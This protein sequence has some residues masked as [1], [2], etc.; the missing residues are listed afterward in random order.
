MRLNPRLGECHLEAFRR[1]SRQAGLATAIPWLWYV[2]MRQGR[3]SSRN[4]AWGVEHGARR[5][6]RV[7]AVLTFL[8]PVLP[9][10]IGKV[11]R[12]FIPLRVVFSS[13]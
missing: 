2:R 10:R 1:G 5:A 7:A 6:L 11:S 9:V 12:V 4:P 8:D 13:L 3:V